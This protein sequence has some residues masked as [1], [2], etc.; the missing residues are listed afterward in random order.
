MLTGGSQDYY[1]QV[2]ELATAAYP[3]VYMRS[4]ALSCVRLFVTRDD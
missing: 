4:K 2:E 3:V 1:P